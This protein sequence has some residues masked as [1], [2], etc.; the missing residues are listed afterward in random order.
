MHVRWSQ[1]KIRGCCV[2][3]RSGGEWNGSILI[4][5][6]VWLPWRRAKRL[7]EFINSKYLGCSRSTKMT[8]CERSHPS[9][10]LN[11][12]MALQTN[13][14]RSGSTPFYYSTKQKM[15]QFRSAYQTQNEMAQFLETGIKPPHSNWLSNQTHLNCY[16]DI[17][18]PKGLKSHPPHYYIRHWA[19]M[20]N[21]TIP[22]SLSSTIYAEMG[23]LACHRSWLPT[24]P[25]KPRFWPCATQ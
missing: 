20:L 11:S 18:S 14:K 5:F 6:Y 17:I 22:S 24:K 10:P 9:P 19:C 13:N 16:N 15:E 21:W 23:N 3:L 1:E 7:L 25:L 12:H 8:G 2:W 4:Y